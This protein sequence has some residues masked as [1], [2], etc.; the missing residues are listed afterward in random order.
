LDLLREIKRRRPQAAVIMET[1]ETLFANAV[2]ALRGGADDFIGKPI[3]LD[4]LRFSLHHS[5]ML[6]LQAHYP[7]PVSQPRV[8][9]MSDYAELI[10]HWQ[11]AFDSQGVETT[12]A[13]FPEEWGYVSGDR[14]DLEHRSSI[15]LRADKST[16]CNN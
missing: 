7:I 3:N 8:F 14:H 10:R 6:K 12:C 11:A 2:A 13:V 4:E 9:I 16:V 5:L 15:R 1:A